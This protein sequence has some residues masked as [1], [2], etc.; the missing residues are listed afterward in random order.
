[1]SSNPALVFVFTCLSAVS[2]TTQF[3]NDSLKKNKAIV[4]SCVLK[5]NLKCKQIIRFQKKLDKENVNQCI[6]FRCCEN[7]LKRFMQAFIEKAFVVYHIYFFIIERTS[8]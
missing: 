2:L 8:A 5:C 1:M 3:H 4:F 6:S 7:L